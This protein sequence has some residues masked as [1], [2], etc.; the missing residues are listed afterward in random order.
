M[1]QID[2]PDIL[3]QLKTNVVNLS[4][5]TFKDYAKDLK[6]DAQKTLDNMKPELKK[7]ANQLAE[8]SLTE[9]E[10]AW[11]LNSKKDLIEITALKNAGIAKIK[12]DQFKSSIL[13]VIANTIGQIVKV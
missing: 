13:N 1:T 11:L 5:T 7:W 9:E 8:G 3:N 6:A 10:F 4:Q 12:I 2:F